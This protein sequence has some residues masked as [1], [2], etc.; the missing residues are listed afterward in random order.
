VPRQGISRQWLSAVAIFPCEGARDAESE[1]A[2]AAAF[3]K[4]GWER[5]TRLHRRGDLPDEQ[6]WVNA[7]DGRWLMPDALLITRQ[8][9]EG[10]DRG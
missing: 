2:L 1:R 7:P 6:C 4:G 8:K 10:D 9:G 5:V 3:E